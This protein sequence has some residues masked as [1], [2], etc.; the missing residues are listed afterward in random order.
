MAENVPTFTQL[1]SVYGVDGQSAMPPTAVSHVYI[2]I[3]LKR[4]PSIAGNPAAQERYAWLSDG[5]TERFGS[6]PAL[7]ARSP[8]KLPVQQ[9]I[10]LRIKCAH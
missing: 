7:F 5:F 9:K 3:S 10:Q 8:G 2:G 4:V 6:R 1:T